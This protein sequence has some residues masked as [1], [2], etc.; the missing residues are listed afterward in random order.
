MPPFGLNLPLRRPTAGLKP[1]PLTPEQ[2]IFVKAIDMPNRVIRK[3]K[4]T[5]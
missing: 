3:R 4:I 2:L 5:T 1:E